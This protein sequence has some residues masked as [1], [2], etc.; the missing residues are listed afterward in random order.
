MVQRPKDFGGLGVLDLEK[1]GV[2]LR[3]RWLWNSWAP[4]DRPWK[5]MPIPCS[6]NERKLFS[7]ATIINVRNGKMTK[8]WQDCWIGNRPL[9][10]KHRTYMLL[11][12]SR[13]EL[14]T[15]KWLMGHRSDRLREYNHHPT[16]YRICKSLEHVKACW[17]R[18]GSMAASKQR[19]LHHEISIQNTV[20]WGR[21]TVWHKTFVACKDRTEGNSFCLDG[22][23]REGILEAKGWQ[24]YS[25][26]TVLGHSRNELSLADRVSIRLE[27]TNV[28]C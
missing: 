25:F 4:E 19:H 20:H 24:Q 27:S 2:P 14:C 10:D 23:A 13:T 16:D 12:D 22:D 6:S 26:S 1:F 5:G 7:E 11:Q 3:L 21:K 15:R 28:C 18:H 8:F 17:R 9:K